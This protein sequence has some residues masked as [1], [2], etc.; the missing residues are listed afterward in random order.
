MEYDEKNVVAKMKDICGDKK[1]LLIIIKTQK[2]SI[3]GV[4][5]EKGFK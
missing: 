3:F 1:H 4:Q 2:R 5:I